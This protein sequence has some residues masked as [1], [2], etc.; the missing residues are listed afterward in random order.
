MTPSDYAAWY[1]AIV[2]TVALLWE[3]VRYFREGLR[4]EATA[5]A[6]MVMIHAG[7]PGDRKDHISISVKHLSGPPTTITGVGFHSY[8]STWHKRFQ[9]MAPVWVQKRL[10]LHPIQTGISFASLNC[11][12]PKRLE[13]GSEYSC[14]VEESQI[15]EIMN[16]GVVYDAIGHTLGKRDILARVQSFSVENAA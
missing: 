6:G 13:V 10:K 7:N 3:I 12:Y 9:P 14:L 1:A 16:E 4:L 11:Q 8:R 5:R 15:R 2:A